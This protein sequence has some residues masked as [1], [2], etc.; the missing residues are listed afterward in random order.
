METYKLPPITH[1]SR[2]VLFNRSI[3]GD[4]IDRLQPIL[5]ISDTSPVIPENYN[6]L[7]V[8]LQFDVSGKYILPGGRRENWRAYTPEDSLDCLIREIKEVHPRFGW[9]D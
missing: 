3:I 6:G 4:T 2:F 7:P 9:D 5:G 8:L 1:Y